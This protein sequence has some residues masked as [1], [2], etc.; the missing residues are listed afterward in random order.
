L[1]EFGVAVDS[2]DTGLSY[3]FAVDVVGFDLDFERVPVGELVIP[4][5]RGVG[6]F[7]EDGLTVAAVLEISLAMV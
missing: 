1:F 4:D 3:P 6:V 5:F 2:S 7:E